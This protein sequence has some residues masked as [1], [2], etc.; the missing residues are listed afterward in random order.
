MNGYIALKTITLSGVEYAEGSIIPADAVLPSRVPA[1]ISTK[2]IAVLN[3][4]TPKAPE[5]PQETFLT[6]APIVLP[7]T[8]KNGVL[9]LMATPEDI[10]EAVVILQLNAED[11]VKAIADISRDEILILIDTLESRKTVKTAVAARA[12]A[13]NKTEEEQETGDA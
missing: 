13:L 4:D 6:P 3:E 8:S 9:E 12:E 7:I 2:R 11:A 10:I 5:T 1:L